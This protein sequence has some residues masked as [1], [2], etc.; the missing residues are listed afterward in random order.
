MKVTGSSYGGF[1]KETPCLWEVIKHFLNCLSLSCLRIQGTHRIIAISRS[2]GIYQ[3]L[4]QQPPTRTVLFLGRGSAKG[5]LE[6]L[7]MQ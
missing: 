1:P 2:H 4:L 7:S 6:W 3:Q 5:N